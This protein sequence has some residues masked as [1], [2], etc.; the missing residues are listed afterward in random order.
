MM[1]GNEVIEVIALVAVLAF[2]AVLV[3]VLH[4]LATGHEPTRSLSSNQSES[5]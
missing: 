5:L 4:R 1:S 2:A 3:I